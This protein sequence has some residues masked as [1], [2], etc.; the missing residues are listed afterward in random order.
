ML[1][2]TTSAQSLSISPTTRLSRWP[3]T[4]VMVRNKSAPTCESYWQAYTNRISYT[5]PLLLS[6]ATIRTLSL[7]F[8]WTLGRYVLS[9]V[10]S[11]QYHL[12]VTTTKCAFRNWT[13]ASSYLTSPVVLWSV[14]W[15]DARV[16]RTPCWKNL[17]STRA[18]FKPSFTRWNLSTSQLAWGLYDAVFE[19]RTPWADRNCCNSPEINCSP[20]SLTSSSIVP[21]RQNKSERKSMIEANIMLPVHRT[22]GYC[23]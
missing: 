10:I 5:D 8:S 17:W 2:A 4:F 3:R 6:T 12:T 22:S 7:H 14:D 18:A 11:E 15:Y 23:E 1:D 16:F 13:S 21:K 20:L 19:W 9:S